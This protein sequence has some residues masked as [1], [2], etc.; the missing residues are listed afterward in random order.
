MVSESELGWRTEQFSG[1]QKKGIPVA[2]PQN[3]R[4]FSKHVMSQFKSK[5]PGRTT[6]RARKSKGRGTHSTGLVA[7]NKTHVKLQTGLFY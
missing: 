3:S 6:P 5:V 2:S 7:D 1:Q 4:V